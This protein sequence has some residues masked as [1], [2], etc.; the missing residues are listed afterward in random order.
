MET[1]HQL[2]AHLVRDPRGTAFECSLSQHERELQAEQLVEDEPAPGLVLLMHRLGMVDAAECRGAVDE[3]EPIEH[4]R[5]H[6]VG[7]LAG[8]LEHLI[9]PACDVP[10]VEARLVRLRIDGDELAGAVADEVD[11]RV[12][13]RLRP[14]NTSSLPNT[15]TCM[16]GRS[17]RSRHAWLKKVI[18]RR[19]DPSL[20]SH[21][22]NAFPPRMRRA[23]STSLLRA[24]SL[25]RRRAGHRSWPLACGPGNGGGSTSAGRARS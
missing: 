24:R 19:A 13:H 17:C 3:V 1:R 2:A 22:T 25:P 12:R 15:S 7:E 14:W 10:R 23:S 9:E 6:R 4:R 18:R 8:A 16:P 20:T 5:G 11:H 21:V